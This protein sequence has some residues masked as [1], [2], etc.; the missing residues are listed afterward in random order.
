MSERIFSTGFVICAF[1]LFL[2]FA[3]APPVRAALDSCIV[4]QIVLIRGAS[5]L[6]DSGSQVAYTLQSQDNTENPCDTQETLRFLINSSTGGNFLSSSGKVL[7]LYISKGSHNRYFFYDNTGSENY[8]ITASAGYGTTSDWVVSFSTS[9][10]SGQGVP[11]SVSNNEDD[12]IEVIQANTVI[13]AHYESEE[14]TDYESIP[15]LQ[16]SAG[17]DRLGSVGSPLEFRAETKDPD[18]RQTFYNWTFGDG[19]IGGGKTT[20]HAYQYSGEYIVVLSI[21]NGGNDAVSRINVKIIEPE[22]IITLATLE[23]IEL[24]NNSK[25]E[26]SL[27]GRALI[28]G[29]KAFVFP[30][31]TIIKAGQ[32]ISFSAGTTG[33][34]PAWSGEVDLIVL[35]EP[36]GQNHINKK[37]EEHR[38]TKITDIKNN[39]AILEQRMAV[40]RATVQVDEETQFFTVDDV[41]DTSEKD[42][43]L[44][45]TAVQS[46][47]SDGW[48]DTIKRFFLGTR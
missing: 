34:Y 21:S 37:I 42:V 16:I 23:R 1:A 38:L 18:S 13:S 47:H 44:T 6:K 12:G 33:L 11:E 40:M 17:R 35:G 46:A 36:I 10:S 3:F 41:E 22:I 7:P 48:F 8:I 31:D 19:T 43:T 28:S 9:A 39:I 2:N 30:R 26:V 20:I 15:E 27:F 45:A 29:N 32:S 14:L 24:T 5:G 25:Y 4:S